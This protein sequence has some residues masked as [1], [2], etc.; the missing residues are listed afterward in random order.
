MNW[1]ASCRNSSSTLSTSLRV[2]WESEAMAPPT[3]WTSRAERWRK[4]SA[5]ASSPSDIMRMAQ[6]CS[7]S[8][9][10]VLA[11]LF[12]PGAQHHGHGARILRGEVLRD[13][14]IVFVAADFRCTAC[15]GRRRAGRGV[16][17]G[18]VFL[19]RNLFGLLAA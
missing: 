4:T 17:G 14:Q 11:I 19:G 7:W 13:I 16:A 12:H 8:S 5:A 2:T 1:S 9:V 15:R 10:L 18:G 6:R 3:I